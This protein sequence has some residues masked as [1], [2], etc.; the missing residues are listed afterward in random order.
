MLR[1]STGATLLP[2]RPLAISGDTLSFPTGGGGAAEHPAGHRT[3]PAPRDDRAPKCQMLRAPVLT[4]GR[5]CKRLWQGAERWG[6]EFTTCVNTWQDLVCPA[7]MLLEAPLVLPLQA[8]GA[9][10]VKWMHPAPG[11]NQ[12]LCFQ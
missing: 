9:S 10:P 4:S 2:G 6:Q 12:A 5:E 7:P 11:T 3:A 1:F 8:S